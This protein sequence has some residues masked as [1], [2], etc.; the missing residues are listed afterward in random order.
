MKKNISILADGRIE[1]I[2]DTKVYGWAVDLDGADEATIVDLYLGDV[3][4]ASSQCTSP[5]EDVAE[6]FKHTGLDLSHISSQFTLDVL[7]CPFSKA[8]AAIKELTKAIEQNRKVFELIEVRL[9]RPGLPLARK[10]KLSLDSSVLLKL[11]DTLVER[12]QNIEEYDPFWGRCLSFRKVLERMG[13][14]TGPVLSE[15]EMDL[16]RN[17]PIGLCVDATF[18]GF[19]PEHAVEALAFYR[20]NS[21]LYPLRPNALFD[22]LWYVTHHSDVHRQIASGFSR[23]GLDAYLKDSDS[24]S[25]RPPVSWI[26]KTEDPLVLTDLQSIED[27]VPFVADEI[28]EIE[29]KQ[30]ELDAFVGQLTNK[31]RSGATLAQESPD[32]SISDWHRKLLES[33][34]FHN[35]AEIERNLFHASAPDRDGVF[36]F[37]GFRQPNCRIILFNTNSQTRNL[38][39]TR[40]IKQDAQRLLGTERVLYAS[41]MDL[42]ETCRNNPDAF[43]ICIDGQR[44][45]MPLISKARRYAAA[46]I[47]WT[48]DDPYNLKDHVEVEKFFD[49]IFT[50]DSSSEVRYGLKGRFL[51]LA[52]SAVETKRNSEKYRYDVF[53]C[54]TAWPNRVVLLNRLIS[55]RPQYRFK[56]ALTYNKHIPA[57]PLNAPVVDY[58]KTLSYDDFM[59]FSRRSA[60]TLALH[61][62]FSGTD[63]MAVSS[64]PGPRMFEVAATGSFQIS[65]NAGEDF[66]AL[67]SEDDVDYFDTYPALLNAV[68][69]ALNSGQ[70]QSRADNLRKR[71]AAQHTYM[72]RLSAMLIEIAREVRGRTQLPVTGTTTKPRILCVVHNTITADVFG[73]LEIHQDLIKENLKGDFDFFFLFTRAD[74]KTREV[75]LTDFNYDPLYSESISETSLHEHLEHR[76]FE[77]IFSYLLN[78]FD[79]DGVHFFHFMHNVPSLAH[80]T[81]AAGIPYV[82]SIHD[83]FTACRQFNLLDHNKNYCD[84]TFDRIGDCDI[85]LLRQFNIPVGSQVKRREYYLEVLSRAAAIIFVSENTREKY[86]DIY[87]QLDY[88]TSRIHGA[89]I[90]NSVWRFQR[91]HENSE[92]RELSSSP[93]VVVCGNFQENK[94]AQYFIDALSICADVDLEFHFHGG[95]SEG[96]RAKVLSLLGDR[97]TFHGRYNPGEVDLSKYDFSL[98]LSNWPETYCQTLSEAWAAR[99]VPI[100]TDIGALGAR[101]TEGVTGLKCDPRRPVTLGQILRRIAVSPED[102]LSIR[103]NLTD[104][105]FITQEQQADLYRDTY[106]ELFTPN[107]VPAE[108]PLAEGRFDLSRLQ[109]NRR[110]SRWSSS[111]NNHPEDKIILPAPLYLAE[112][113]NSEYWTGP[114]GIASRGSIDRV[115]VEGVEAPRDAG[116]LQVKND[117]VIRVQGWAMRPLNRAAQDFKPVIAVY[118]YPRVP[119][120]AMLFQAECYVRPDLVKHLN[121]E[122]AKNLGVKGNIRLLNIRKFL[123]GRLEVSIGW[124]DIRSGEVLVYRNGTFINMRYGN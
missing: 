50:N 77:R 97:A 123:T 28:F 21:H 19:P 58:V 70:T 7:D 66:K 71:V 94:G 48:F 29:A 79:F 118:D 117:Q 38:H 83:F 23:S 85:C 93:K 46:T 15:G 61:R 1:S 107:S 6:K 52:V 91:I 81:R 40:Q 47:L 42:V 68:D 45:N 31:A 124:R 100:V 75:F 5:R 119:N 120:E 103:H 57:L 96:A 104:D 3:L 12:V 35:N 80:V 24:L 82:V 65:E 122:K 39:I 11:K 36:N 56:I 51:P 111:K 76:E 25:C 44:M 87:P 10:S 55:D 90:P 32:L 72:N 98:H 9:R 78:K 73:G 101:V 112:A 115:N 49:I 86:K 109:R 63:K 67:F 88:S 18:L 43:L 69:A 108:L 33:G 14:W 53:F 74:Q 62:N 105:L 116:I 113:E 30:S 110:S 59:K 16:F 60:V 13:L 2:E 114:I 41:Q 84:N 102:Y 106:Y 17:D 27:I 121:D 8:S 99:L 26:R 4:V 95:A 22:D 37:L 34:V 64:S 54:G 92:E 89:P 20:I